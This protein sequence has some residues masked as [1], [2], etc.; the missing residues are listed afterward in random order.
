M[1]FKKTKKKML[2]LPCSDYI[3]CQ[4]VGKKLAVVEVCVGKVDRVRS[5][6]HQHQQHQDTGAGDQH[7]L[8]QQNK[9]IQPAPLSQS[10]QY[11]E[12]RG[13]AGVETVLRGNISIIRSLSAGL[14]Q[15]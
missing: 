11:G 1:S 15:L 7:L 14:Y 12:W 9:D 3:S 5:R 8:A 10:Q 2:P 13:G 4:S 6:H